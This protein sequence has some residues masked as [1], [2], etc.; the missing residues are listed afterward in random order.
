[1]EKLNRAIGGYFELELKKS[2]SYYPDAIRLNSAR[3]ALEYV[4][5]VRQYS[6]VYIPYYTCDVILEPLIKLDIPFE[7]YHINKDLEP[8]FNYNKIGLKE[9]FLYNNYFGIK[10]LFIKHL[11]AKISNLI[12][13]NA[14]SF[15]STPLKGID[16]FYSPRKFFGVSDGAYLSIDK[17]LKDDFQQDTSHDRMSHLLIRA[18]KNAEEGYADFG[19]N[20]SCLINEPIK[21][22]SNLTHKLLCSINYDL[23]KRKR[24]ENFNY[25]HDNLNKHNNLKIENFEENIPMVYPLWTKNLN[26]KKRLLDNQIYCATYW[27]NVT[28]WCDEGDIELQLMTEIVN[29]PIDQRYSIDDM[30]HII[31]TLKKFEY[32]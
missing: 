15:F 16:T 5:R 11:S 14:Q 18:D 27:P 3:N 21:K 31:N 17:E 30:N 20:D 13:D 26:L 12:I 24:I 1:M 23:V 9:G 29:L 32:A 25:L 22:M 10:N 6:K 2:R 4:L 8:V 7:F 28:N 19:F